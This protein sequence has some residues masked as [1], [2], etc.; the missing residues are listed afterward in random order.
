MASFSDVNGD[1]LTDLVVHVT[2]EA[3][4]LSETDTIA[5][6]EGTTFSGILFTGTDTVRIVPQ[7]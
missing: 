5:I 4:E 7:E 2:T 6:L 1:F 3:L